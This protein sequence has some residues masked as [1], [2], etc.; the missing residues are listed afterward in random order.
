MI[1]FQYLL[2]LTLYIRQ[3]HIC[4]TFSRRIGTITAIYLFVIFQGEASGL[5]IF[6]AGKK[7][8]SVWFLCLV[9]QTY[10]KILETARKKVFIFSVLRKYLTGMAA[11]ALST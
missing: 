5:S 7:I 1:W 2:I 9:F 6:R 11:S 4:S 10:K 8:E 3:N